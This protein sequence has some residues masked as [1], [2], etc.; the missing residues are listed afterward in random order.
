M[1]KFGKGNVALY[2]AFRNPQ[3]YAPHLIDK[4]LAV[5]HRNLSV[6]TQSGNDSRLF[7]ISHH[8]LMIE[9]LPSLLR[10]IV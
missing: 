1:C 4:K 10:Y 6:M 7:E 8:P 2:D 3:S 5:S 9:I